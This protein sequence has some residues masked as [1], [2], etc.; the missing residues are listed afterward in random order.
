MSKQMKTMDQLRDSQ[1]LYDKELPAFGYMIILMIAILLIS[2][3]IWSIKAPKVYMI[4]S[5]GTIQSANKNY[6]MSPYTGELIDI[7]ISEGVNV[8]KGD[9]IFTVKSTDLDL[10]S[11]QLKEQKL[12]YEAQI[13]QYKKLILSIKDDT[14]YFDLNNA[15]DNLYYS[16]YEAYKSQVAQQQVDAS[17][18]KT[19]GYTDEQIEVELIKNQNKITEIYYSSLKSAEDSMQQ[20][21]TQ[22]DSIRAQLNAI[23]SGQTEY[24]VIAN[25]TG[26]IHMME[27]YKSGMVVQAASAVA[28]IASEQDEYIV[29]AYAS[30]S[31]AV[32]V[33]VGD[34]VEIEVSGLI[35]TIYGTLSGTVTKIDSDITT[36]KNEAENGQNTYFKIEINPDYN[37]L[38]SKEG[39][40]V[41]IS[42]GMVVE[43]RIQYDKI[44]YFNYILEALGV[45]TR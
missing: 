7:Y 12:T 14:N 5:S 40:K 38:V 41:N 6:V 1:L 11:E 9:V 19:Y 28:S 16:Q 29:Q 31:D 44:T 37:Y 35:Q 30:A 39:D 15:A 21:Q 13:T 8:E 22:L 45:L 43:T 2:I 34:H 32:K 36:M 10:Q 25:E 24:K 20:C 23:G 42:N 27:E 26:K 17:A 3:I 33:N 4:Q 18:Y